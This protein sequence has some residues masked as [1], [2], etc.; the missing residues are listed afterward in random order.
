[1]NGR[2]IIGASV[3]EKEIEDFWINMW[4]EKE[5]KNASYEEY[6]L[7]CTPDRNDIIMYPTIDEFGDIIRYLPNWKAAGVDKRMKLL[8]K[9]FY[10]INK[11]IIVEI[12][13]NQ[14]DFIRV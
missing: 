8:H 6:L 11:G 9:T 5:G 14:A 2:P 3:P 4:N 12:P 1:M 7:E 10:E 13:N